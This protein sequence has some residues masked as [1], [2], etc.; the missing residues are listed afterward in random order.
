MIHLIIFHDD[1]HRTADSSSVSVSE[2][3]LGNYTDSTAEAH[4]IV[5]EE[6]KIKSAAL[7]V[8]WHFTR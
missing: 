5:D 8:E 2:Q 1:K 3:Y 7:P 6:H 4:N